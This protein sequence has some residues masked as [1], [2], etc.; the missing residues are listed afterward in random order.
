MKCNVRDIEV[1]YEVYGEGKPIIALHG[2]APDHRLMSGCL[3]SVFENR[4]GYKRIYIDLPGRGK[5]KGQ[6]WVKISD[7]ILDILVD[8]IDAVIPGENFLL[9]GE[10]HG[11]YLSRGVVNKLAQ[12]IDGLFL[13]CP[14]IFADKKKKDVPGKIVFHKDD[15]LLTQ[16][17][18]DVAKG[19]DAMHVVQNQAIWQR[20][21][22]E[23][24]SGIKLADF[25]FIRK[26]TTKF[27]FEDTLN[28]AFDKP[29][30]FLLGRQDASVGYK[31]AW[32]ILE[33]YPRATFAVLD[34][35]GHNLQFEQVEL[36]NGL[37]NEWLTRI[38]TE[39]VNS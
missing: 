18:P 19:F 6:E 39:L 10:S 13:L 23:I 14:E 34:K 1:N 32:S 15:D 38:E 31:N 12:R 16:L 25:D 8:F 17:D 28:E 24:L 11:G 3:E 22:D 21:R 35:A 30:L 20:Y 36:F 5:T 9:A 33:N 37:V 29:T 27:S 4:P 2:Y 26:V 7:D